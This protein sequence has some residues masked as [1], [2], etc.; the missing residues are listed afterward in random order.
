[1][2]RI[3][4]GALESKAQNVQRLE[5]LC[6]SLCGFCS[7]NVSLNSFDDLDFNSVNQDST[8]PKLAKM[9]KMQ[10]SLLGH[11]RMSSQLL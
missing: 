10:V 1:M 8:P 4:L 5:A 7:V 3:V 6:R 9:I 11:D 2:F